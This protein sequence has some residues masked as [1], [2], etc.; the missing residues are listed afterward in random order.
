MSRRRSTT[1]PPSRWLLVSQRAGAGEVTPADLAGCDQGDPQGGVTAAR[2]LVLARFPD[3][4]AAWLA[5]SVVHGTATPTSDLD[6]TVLLDGPPAPFRESLLHR[7]WPVELFVHHADS[8]EHWLAMDRAAPPADAR[9][10]D[11]ERRDAARR[12]RRRPGRWPAT[13][14]AFLAAGPEPLGDAERDAL[15]YRLTDLLDDL[16]GDRPRRSDARSPIGAVRAGEP[17]AARRSGR[18][19]GSRQVAG[20]RARGV[21]RR[22]RHPLRVPPPRRAGRRDRWRAG[23]LLDVVDEILDVQAG[24]S[25]RATGSAADRSAGRSAPPPPGVRRGAAGS[26]RRRAVPS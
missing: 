20:A 17:A 1:V 10:A 3:A 24:G 14:D 4:R 5:G 25:G 21:R 12:R 8:V 6:V 15:R 2:E 26:G 9:P 22:A 13:C 23:E 19:W 18:W 11:R 16:A 7:G